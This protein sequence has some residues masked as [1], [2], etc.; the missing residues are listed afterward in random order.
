MEQ[1]QTL[2]PI[3]KIMSSRK[4][5]YTFLLERNVDPRLSFKQTQIQLPASTIKDS[6]RLP[7][8]LFPLTRPQVWLPMSLNVPQRP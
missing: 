7:N 6:H 2:H 5:M 3:Y 1:I 8:V 4:R